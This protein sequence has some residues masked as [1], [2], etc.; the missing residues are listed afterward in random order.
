MVIGIRRVEVSYFKR[1]VASLVVILFALMAMSLVS[2]ADIYICLSDGCSYDNSTLID[3]LV[4]SNNTGNTI[5]INES[6]YYSFD[7]ASTSFFNITDPS[8]NGT[9]ILAQENITFDCQSALLQGNGSGIGILVKTYNN[10]SIINCFVSNYTYNYYLNG[11]NDTAIFN[12]NAS[13]AVMYGFYLDT[14]NTTLMSLVIQNCPVGVSLSNS[15]I[16]A[17][18]NSIINDSRTAGIMISLSNNLTI[19]GNNISYTG[20]GNSLGNGL[21]INN[22]TMNGYF[23]NNYI[24][25]SSYHGIYVTSSSRNITFSAQRLQE[26]YIGVMIND[27]STL[28]N[29]SDSQINKTNSFAILIYNSNSAFVNRVNATHSEGHS[30]QLDNSSWSRLQDV[31]IFNASG[32][33]IVLTNSSS[34]NNITDCRIFHAGYHGLEFGS[35][36]N[37]NNVLRTQINDSG[38]YNT[39]HGL[40]IENSLGN[41][42]NETNI[43]F[44]SHMGV[45]IN[46]SNSTS[47]NN[48]RVTGSEHNGISLQDSNQG[49]FSNN[50]VLDSTLAGLY[51]YDSSFN[52]FINNSINQ[53]TNTPFELHV[54]SLSHCAQNFSEG[55]FLNDKLIKFFVGT[56]DVDFTNNSE[57]AYLGIV[58]SNNISLHD[59]ALST[60]YER[61]VLLCNASRSS[62][63]NINI[64]GGPDYGIEIVQSTNNTIRNCR[65]NNTDSNSIYM[66][67]SDYNALS[68]N[69]ILAGA[70]YGLFL[71]SSDNNTINASNNISS[72]SFGGIY[73]IYSNGTMIR[74]NSIKHNLNG[75]ILSGSSTTSIISFNDI[76]ENTNYD[77]IN[78]QNIS[79]VAENN[80]WGST[81]A[82]FVDNASIQD[83]EDGTPAGYAVDFCPLLNDTFISGASVACEFPSVSLS[84]TTPVSAQNFTASGSAYDLNF[85]N[86]TFRIEKSDNSSMRWVNGSFDTVNKSFSTIYQGLYLPISIWN[87]SARCYDIYNHS[88]VN[89]SQI[90]SIPAIVPTIIGSASGAGTIGGDEIA[91]TFTMI[92][93]GYPFIRFFMNLT[94]GVNVYDINYAKIGNSTERLNISNSLTYSNAQNFNLSVL[95]ASE[96]PQYGMYN[97]IYAGNV[98]LF[99]TPYTGLS[100]GVYYGSYGWG[101]FDTP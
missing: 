90:S 35:G 33:G 11:S 55:N 50:F 22:N 16:T 26:T 6:G 82:Y 73:L 52:N 75:I 43:T 41:T 99:L 19:S 74:N 83:D 46:S 58:N 84:A 61:A 3:A 2:A 96:M 18:Y 13:N 21:I 7:S 70:A 98:S 37:Y 12:S 1:T 5:I 66:V 86:C 20:Y 67:D 24:F 64:T 92:S 48:N 94:S 32:F 101:L 76:L 25:N 100:A 68:G 87:L 10:I 45:V 30:I 97:M 62:L 79:I 65:I 31:M 54:S 51:I 72:N 78:S 40:A 71:N 89:T 8:G 49:V 23:Y 42:I 85:S 4:A 59:M 38:W 29:I 47:F 77:L 88:Y 36:S 53:S 14:V 34:Y 27:N 17:L 95:S 15:N 63:S 69:T 91:F 56:Q 93:K 39:Y 81:W 44:S 57:I 9:I 80:Y 28:I 60:G